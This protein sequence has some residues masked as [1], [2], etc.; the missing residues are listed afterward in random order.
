MNWIQGASPKRGALHR[1]LGYSHTHPL[2]H[3]LLRDIENANIGTHIRGHKV[4]HLL[5][6]RVNFAI[7]AQKRLR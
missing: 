5:K 7:N 6:E 1:Q 2:P 3:G 4:T